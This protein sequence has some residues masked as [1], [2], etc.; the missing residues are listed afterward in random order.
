MCA[1]CAM[2]ALAGASGFR[3]WLQNRGW[4]WLTPKRLKRATAVAFIAAIAVSSVGLSGSTQ[5]S[6]AKS[7]A[8]VTHQ[9]DR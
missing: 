7:G 9:A 5:P 1:T 6:A 4:S 3:A 8:A 2:T